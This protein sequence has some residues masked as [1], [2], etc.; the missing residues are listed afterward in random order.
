M[1]RMMK[2][3]LG[4]VMA[5]FALPVFA[6]DNF[7]DVP[8]NHWAYQALENMKREGILVGYPDGMFRG[9]RPASR[10]EMAV[11]INAAYQKLMSMMSGMSDQLKALDDKVNG[12]MGLPG[13]VKELRDQLAALKAKWEKAELKE[14]AGAKCGSGSAVRDH[15]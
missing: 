12:L 3:A 6:Q 15:Q 5:S 4:A 14:S 2:I 7:P 11:A 13:E 1:N 9:A 8:D 10:Y